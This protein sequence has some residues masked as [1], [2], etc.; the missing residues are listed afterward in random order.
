MVI[1]DIERDFREKVCKSVSLRP[2]GVNRYRVFTPFMF[3]DGDHL[4]MVLKREQNGW[5]LSDEGH[6]LMHLTYSISESD[7]QRGTRQKI[8]TDALSAFSVQDR[9][10]ELVAPIRDREYGHVLYSFV[11]AVLK[12][13]DVTFLTRERVRSTFMEDF[14]SFMVE[15][16][17][18]ERREF[19]WHHSEHDPQGMYPVDCRVNG[20]K[21][22]L[23]V[24]A[25]PSDSKTMVATISILQYEKW[26]LPFRSLGILEDQEQIGRKV[27]AR[28]TDVCER[29]FSSLIANRERL[30]RF[31]I[32]VMGT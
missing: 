27:L 23:L 31:L 13:S 3:D 19:N 7:L 17:P 28:F 9:E 24:F 20:T 32:E 15:T 1:G 18:E 22:P 11:Q 2:E 10:G 14:R 26:G 12:I 29:Q 6:T 21:R 30:A 25:L 5:I 4:A 8:I 16:V